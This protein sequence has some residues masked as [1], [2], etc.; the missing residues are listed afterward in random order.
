MTASRQDIKAWH[1][2]AT[3]ALLEGRAREAHELCLAILREDKSHADAW[4]LCGVIAGQNGQRHKAAEILKNAVRLNRKNPEYAAELGKYLLAN[5]QHREALEAANLAFELDPKDVPTL[6][7]L[8]T[9]L[10]HCGEHDRAVSCFESAVKTLDAKSVSA[11]RFSPQFRGELFFN[12]AV[13]LQFAGQFDRAE[14]AYESAIG[15]VPTL[16]RAHSALASLRGQTQQENHLERL[17]ALKPDAVS[18]SDKLHLGHAIAKELEDIGEYPAAFE[19]LVWAKQAQ[20]EKVQYNRAHD[21]EL[22]AAVR[23]TYKKALSSEHPNQGYTSN[24]PIFIVGLPRS[25]TT[26][27]EQILASHSSVFAAGELQN[28][29]ARVKQLSATTSLDNLDVETLQAT[30]GFDMALL[31]RSYIDSTRPRTGNTPYF[32][33]KLPLNFLY[34]GLIK[35]ALPNAKIICLRRDPMDVCLS[36]YRQ[37]F[38]TNFRYYFYNLNILDCGRYYIEFDH[39][40]QYW[41]TVMPGA[42]YE[43]Q[44]ETLVN[45]PESE[46]RNLLQYCEL[47]WEDACL[48]FS[49]RRGSVATPSAVQVRSGMYT[50]AV[51]R[52]RKYAENL[53]PLYALLQENGY[54]D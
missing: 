31:G 4:F 29:P 15:L 42:V 3:T 48:D 10:S 39:L 5:G 46:I 45:Q 50:S 22:F 27:V 28:F 36:N 18:A 38:A 52:W 19:S 9:L 25:G 49:Q 7:T 1:T 2:S 44:Y 51:E 20:A 43:I 13:S 11:N 47:P 26:L 33:D 32:T 8:G 16:F 30:E 53:Q 17:T 34:I 6:N 21:S 37:L 24:E 14:R 41:Q 23:N 12:M 40:M 35:R 54:Y